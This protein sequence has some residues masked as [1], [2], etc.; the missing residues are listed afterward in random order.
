MT[1]RFR[2]LTANL[3]HGRSDPAAFARV[4]ANHDPDVV[5]VQELGPGPADVL[6]SAYPNVH[7]R[8]ALD[9]TGR[10]VASRFEGAMGDIEMPGRV[11]VGASLAVDEEIVRVAGVHLLNP[12]HFPWWVSARRRGEQVAELFRWLDDN[13]GPAVVV[14]DFNASP[15][16]PAY[17]KV[18]NRL[19]DLVISSGEGPRPTW[20]Y[21]PGWPL[22]LRIDHVF[23]SGLAASNIDTPAI[24]GSDHVAIVADIQLVNAE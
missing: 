12:V 13:P 19:D 15:R 6:A 16:W 14:G 21:R 10:G 17:K 23:G 5:V 22:M 4:V 9:F 7:L 3:L 18:A 8:P 2:L 11:G 20:G 24:D 1:A